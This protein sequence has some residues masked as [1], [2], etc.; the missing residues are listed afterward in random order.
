M[1]VDLGEENAH[2]SALKSDPFPKRLSIMHTA[3][4]GLTTSPD[5][6]LFVIR[7]QLGTLTLLPV[8]L[9]G[10]DGEQILSEGMIRSVALTALAVIRD[11]G[12][13]LGAAI[14]QM[15]LKGLR[16]KP[17]VGLN[18]QLAELNDLVNPAGNV[19]RLN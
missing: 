9:A 16:F 8:G 17:G 5:S 18:T 13:E 10:Q 14:D 7:N 12:L 4:L 1:K 2:K 19:R 11:D 6:Q 15:T 3:L